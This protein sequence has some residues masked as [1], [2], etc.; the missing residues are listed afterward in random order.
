MANEVDL[1]VVYFDMKK[2]KRGQYSIEFTVLT[3]D[4][5]SLPYGHLTEQHVQLLENSI[6][7]EPCHWLWSHKRWK[8]SMPED[9][10]LLKI[11][12]KS[13]FEKKYR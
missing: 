2:T 12:Q 1:N 4:P 3:T 6:M 5:R 13:K 9:L 8:R 7:D 11:E 10:E